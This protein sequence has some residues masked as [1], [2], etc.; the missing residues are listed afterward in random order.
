MHQHGCKR[1]R[2]NAGV[3]LTNN[4]VC[5]GH[6]IGIDRL[7]ICRDDRQTGAQLG[8]FDEGWITDH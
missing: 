8:D 2:R 6:K 5:P 7:Q 4:S 3:C 1:L